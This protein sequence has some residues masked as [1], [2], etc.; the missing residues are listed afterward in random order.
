M[1]FF[2]ILFQLSLLLLLSNYDFIKFLLLNLFT[3]MLLI[4]RYIYKLDLYQ[5][6]HYGQLHMPITITQWPITL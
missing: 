3:K 4:V 5:Q 2:I 6:L 1:I